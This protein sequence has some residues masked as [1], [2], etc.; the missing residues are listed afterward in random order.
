MRRGKLTLAG[1]PT[2][3]LCAEGLHT[4]MRVVEAW[5]A[6][7]ALGHNHAGAACAL[8]FRNIAA[9]DDYLDE[10]ELGHKHLREVGADKS[11]K[12]AGGHRMLHVSS[13]GP[14]LTRG[15]AA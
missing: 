15:T 7:K 6:A 3:M 1:T 9:D 2:Q 8:S 4:R 11:Y 10:Y 5:E 13:I 14:T 12:M